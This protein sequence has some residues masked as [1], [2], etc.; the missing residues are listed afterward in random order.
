MSQPVKESL[1]NLRIY[2]KEVDLALVAIKV[3]GRKEEE[4]VEAVA[5]G[6]G[7]EGE[8]A[9]GETQTCQVQDP[10]PGLSQILQGRLPCSLGVSLKDIEARQQQR[11]TKNSS[12]RRKR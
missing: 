7:E 11:L 8:R 9:A 4:V 10:V 3:K 5:E 6:A 12:K 2:L 1:S